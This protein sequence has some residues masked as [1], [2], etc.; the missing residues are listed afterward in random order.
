MSTQRIRPAVRGLVMDQDNCVLMVKLVFPHGAWWVLPGGGIDEGEDHLTA[1]HRELHEETGLV[2]APIG[3]PVWNRVHV[4]T[5]T[6]TDGH[7]WD[8]Q[9]ETAYLVRT[10]RF[11]PTPFFTDA[12]LRRENLCEHKWWSL[13]ELFAYDGNDNFSPPDLA[14]YIHIV[15]NEGVPT[16][17][18]QMFHSS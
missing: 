18:F 9:S 14:S 5:M 1:L 6:D 15:V 7:E 10:E 11:I 12:E 13:A 4:F 16:T 2:N 8:G 3:P 17:P